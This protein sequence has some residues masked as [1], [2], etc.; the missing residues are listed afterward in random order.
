MMAYCVLLSDHN[1]SIYVVLLIRNIGVFWTRNEEDDICNL[2]NKE[3]ILYLLL[4]HLYSHIFKI[5][6]VK[7]YIY[8]MN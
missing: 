3:Y 8:K 1:D 7:I 5:K 2:I 4:K 6:M